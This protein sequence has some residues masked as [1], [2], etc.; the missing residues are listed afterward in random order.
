MKQYQAIGLM[1]G[2]SLDGVDAALLH[3]D[4]EGYIKPQ[5][6]VHVEYT[7]ELR[8]KTRALFNREP[9]AAI[10]RE[11]TLVNAA[12]VRA[13]LEKYGVSAADIDVVGYHGQTI[14]HA[15]ERGYTCQIGDGKLLAQLVGINVVND[16]R[17]ADVKAG[18]QGAPLVPVYHQAM[19]AALEK[20]V[21]ILN[22]GGVANA[23][24]IGVA[25]ELVAFDV[26][27]G[28]ALLDD[29]MLQHTGSR[30]DQ[31]GATAA[32]GT[33]QEAVLQKLL[34]DEY[35]TRPAPKSLDR[36]H[37]SAAPVA[38]LA[39]ED[40]AATLAAF[41][42][43]GVVKALEHFPAAPKQWFVAGGGRYNAF[44]MRK[45]AEKLGVS[46]SDIASLGFN[47]DATEAEAWAYLAVRSLK[48]LPITFPLT[49]G[50]TTPM[51]GGVLHRIA[52]VAA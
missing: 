14:A 40:G 5:G 8:E 27:P 9:D 34:S 25:G 16:L 28:N 21:A 6:A 15:P 18:G 49:T 45:M 4:G 50:V 41:T 38:A 29:W 33:V 11:L 37:F 26:G 39:L 32:R 2:T 36:N 3:T 20:P 17:M 44:F 7:P 35:F 43:A 46:V 22:I 48:S 51:T 52:D 12:A 30:F 31:D 19:A 10:A 13:L 1:S 47:G 23:T 42:V 24:Y